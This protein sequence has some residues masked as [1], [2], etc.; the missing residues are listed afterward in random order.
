MGG[1]VGPLRSSPRYKP[2]DNVRLAV[3]IVLI[4]IGGIYETERGVGDLVGVPMRGLW[5][6]TQHEAHLPLRVRELAD[7]RF[8][9]LAAPVLPNVQGTA[10]E[11]AGE[12]ENASMDGAR[13]ADVALG[14]LSAME[15]DGAADVA[16]EFF[17]GYRYGGGAYPEERIAA[18]IWCEASGRLDPGGYHLGLGQFDPGTWATV[19]AITGYTD[20]RDAYSQGF[21]VAVWASMISPGTAAGW[22]H[23]W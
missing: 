11:A 7:A 12:P 21:N 2:G 20:W 9:P 22:P 18:M 1:C 13:T 4:A 5:D 17:N 3:L 23:C 16:A 15:R 14:S 19:S 6:A 8:V 10:V